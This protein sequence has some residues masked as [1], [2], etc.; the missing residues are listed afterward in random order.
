MRAATLLVIAA[1]LYGLGVMDPGQNPDTPK[2]IREVR[3]KVW[4]AIVSEHEPGRTD[5]ALRRLQGWTAEQLEELIG[6]LGEHLGRPS[7][8]PIKTPEERLLL[9]RRGAVLHADIAM[10]ARFDDV[11]APTPQAS[12]LA[13]PSV[14]VDD[15][16]A[17]GFAANSVHWEIG[18]HLID[19]MIR[20][21]L[22]RAP[23]E[24]M[25][26]WYRAASE[27]M[28]AGA[29]F[30]ATGPHLRRAHDLLPRDPHVWLASGV[31]RASYAAP[32]V[33]N[34]MAGVK[35]PFGLTLLV[36]D[37]RTELFSAERYFRRAV[38]IDPANPEAQL[39]YGWVLLQ[40][41]QRERALAALRTA[42]AASG[43][44]VLQYYASLFLGVAE[45]EAAPNAAADAFERAA[46]LFPTAQA[47][48]L[49]LS[50]LA[51]RRGDGAAAVAA[52]DRL[53]ALPTSGR[54][55]PWWTYDV[56]FGRSWRA[57]LARMHESLAQA[58]R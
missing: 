19:L 31:V 10:L 6:G 29:D 12:R 20:P 54:D 13:I 33:Q 56:E 25:S 9:L 47:P 8:L 35:V 36:N 51:L 14:V 26:L 39:R 27:F 58:G 49:A 17:T 4:I 18:R 48:L 34:N 30:A 22:L 41:N 43:E 7:Q 37:R 21:D 32:S 24:F 42:H 2:L 28:I 1:P 46:R 53:A 40:Q 52:L 5:A 44:L 23:D 38:E 45:A 57:T 3:V 55:D 16:R 50:E 15:G 11:V